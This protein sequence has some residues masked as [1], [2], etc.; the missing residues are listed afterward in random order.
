MASHLDNAL[1]Q[2]SIEED[3]EPFVLPD[4]PEYY[5]TGRN[6][7]SLVGRLLNPQC[8]DMADFIL[9]MSRKWKLYGRVRGVALTREKFQFIFTHE[10]D[11]LNVLNK[12][13]HTHNLW[14]IVLERWVEKPP[15]DYLQFIM[16]W[17]QMRNIPINHYTK[18]ALWS[19]GDFAGQVVE[20][21]FDPDKP[22]IKEYVRVLVRFDVSKPPRRA[23]K[24]T[25]PGGDTVNILYDYERIQKRC[26]T[27]Q[28]LTHEQ[29]SCPI[30]RNTKM[31]N[32]KTAGSSSESFDALS[33]KP[34]IAKEVME[35]MRLYLRAAEGAERLAREERVKK[36]FDDLEND[37]VGQKTYLR[38]EPPPSVTKI[39]DKRKGH[40]Y[41]FIAQE[42]KTP[43]SDKLMASAIS[44]GTK[45]LQSG[46]VVSAMPLLMVH[47]DSSLP[48]FS[49]QSSTGYSAGSFVTSASGTPIKK[50]KGRRR[51]GTFIRKANGKGTLK[52]DASRGSKFGEGVFTDS[53]RKAKEDV[54]P[55]QSS[56]RFKKPLVV[57]I[58]GPSNI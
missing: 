36:S 39:L 5:S 4:H 12:G 6:A 50:P 24:V 38:L 17:V 20:V 16:V 11:M 8:Q 44:A 42:V 27:F 25:T 41:D 49:A 18:K 29:L 40:V 48:E 52:A 45:S 2:L 57:P 26:Y 34:K 21:A 37:P 23:K 30:Y 54:E 22:Q 15:E 43:R 1:R 53:K 32:E 9:N 14:P 28:R 13:V 46:K 55:S 3:E 35:D 33:G 7:L 31:L 58:E 19:L 47:S 10:H 56:A 51:P